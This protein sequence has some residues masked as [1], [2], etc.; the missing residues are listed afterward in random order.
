MET[1]DARPLV[2][3]KVGGS[4]L[5]WPAFPDGL[6]AYLEQRVGD[7]LVV[8]VGGGRAAD[9]VRDLDR[10][11]GL[12]PGRSHA[13]ALRALD[14]TAHVAAALVPGLDL[15]ESPG[16]FEGC[17]RSGR[18]PLLAPGR[19]LDR[20]DRESD[21]PL[22]HSWDVTTDAIAARL[23]VHLDASELALLKSAPLPKGADRAEAARLGLV[24]PAFRAEAGRLRLVTY[25][26]LRDETPIAVTLPA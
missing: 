5:G 12:G 2:V 4:L 10:D 23:A 18:I 17:W 1:H 11:H 24:D 6:A 3:V 15:V 8:V 25:V 9:W 7:R 20:Q 16:S 19:F 26:N 14:L 22:P 21:S 13:L